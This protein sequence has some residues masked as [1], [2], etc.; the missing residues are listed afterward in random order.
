LTPHQKLRVLSSQLLRLGLQLGD[1][2]GGDG[3]G[4][5]QL[6]GVKDGVGSWFVGRFQ[7]IV[8][9]KPVAKVK[10]FSH[11]DDRVFDSNGFAAVDGKVAQFA[12]EVEFWYAV[13]DPPA[14]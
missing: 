8:P 9:T 10:E 1:R 2:L 13:R 4:F 12:D 14:L 11:R 7:P 6:I 5:G 3:R